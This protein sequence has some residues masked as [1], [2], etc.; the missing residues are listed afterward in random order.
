MWGELRSVE[1]E[2]VIELWVVVEVPKG[3]LAIS[4]ALGRL[5]HCACPNI[6]L[7]LRVGDLYGIDLG[8]MEDEGSR[9]RCQMSMCRRQRV[10]ENNIVLTRQL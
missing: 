8:R 2:F 4:D 7:S 3:C 6:S 1:I 9:Y 5:G 10:L